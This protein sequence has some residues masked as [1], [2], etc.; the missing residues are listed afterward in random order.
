VSTAQKPR[1]KYWICD[2][3]A[4][5]KGWESP[6]YAVTAILGACAWCETPYEQMLIPVVDYKRLGKVQVW[7]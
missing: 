6:N 5:A 1:D 4:K 2:D 3:C 7:D